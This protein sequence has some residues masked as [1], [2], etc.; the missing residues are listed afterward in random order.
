M[1][2]ARLVDCGLR[3]SRTGILQGHAHAAR[4][5]G[6]SRLRSR[7]TGDREAPNTANFQDYGRII[8]ILLISGATQGPLLDGIHGTVHLLEYKVT[9]LLLLLKK[10]GGS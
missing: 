3:G 7:R 9:R 8:P 4:P 6:A 1:Q 2:R 5:W 10:K